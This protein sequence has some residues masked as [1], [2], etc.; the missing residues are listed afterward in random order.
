VNNGLGVPKQSS[1]NR[2]SS[3]H[4]IK[5]SL[6]ELASPGRHPRRPQLHRRQHTH[7]E[8]KDKPPLSSAILTGQTRRSL[9]IPLSTATPPLMSPSPSRQGS[10]LALKEAGDPETMEK[11]EAA[12]VMQQEEQACLRAE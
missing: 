8:D 10:T 9:D 2:P 1:L 5:R 6:S 12:K 7:Y 4:Q 11:R 3:R